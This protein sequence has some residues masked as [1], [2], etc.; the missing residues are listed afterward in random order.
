MTLYSENKEYQHTIS[1]VT[2]EYLGFLDNCPEVWRGPWTQSQLDTFR[3]GPFE[4][5][6]I[7]HKRNFLRKHFLTLGEMIL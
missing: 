5:Q 2:E 3:I 1:A 6:Y 7:D 4:Q